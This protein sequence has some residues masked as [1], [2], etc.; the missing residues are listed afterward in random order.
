MRVR[1]IR[2]LSQLSDSAFFESVAEGLGLVLS[3]AVR[4][5]DGA[6]KVAQAGRSRASK[7]LEAI[8]E[9]ESAKFLV[10]MD[11]VRCPKQPG[12]RFA[13]Q[14]SRF[15][16]HLAKGLYARACTWR[17]T[18]LGELQE[19][20]DHDRQ[21]FYLDGPN[22]SDWIFRN[23]IHQDR[24]STLYVDYV[25]TDEGHSWTDPGQFEELISGSIEPFS[26]EMA[27]AL[28]DVGL[29]TSRGLSVVARV[30]RTAEI[31]PNTSCSEFRALNL[32]T[33]DEVRKDGLLREE[34]TVCPWI[35]DRWQ[36]PMYDLDLSMIPVKLDVLR[37][38]QRNWS[39]E[40]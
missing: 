13:G 12:A 32:R 25:A 24:E 35:V 23:Q 33:L 20:I 34:S 39:P 22:E 10:L 8:A 19:Y 31:N 15:S 38:Q 28:S 11:A 40:W 14:L 30:W 9:E 5:Y 17:P 2:D 7:V 16:E 1:A 3:N 21:E 29:A 26:L 36:F 4:L 27:R 18:T 37:E 6:T